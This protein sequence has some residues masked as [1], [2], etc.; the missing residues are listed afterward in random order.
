MSYKDI[1]T[2]EYFSEISKQQLRDMAN[3]STWSRRFGHNLRPYGLART[4]ILG[5]VEETR[6]R[7][8]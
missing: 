4:I 3:S 2:I 6:R 5:A 1:I 7:E 8:T